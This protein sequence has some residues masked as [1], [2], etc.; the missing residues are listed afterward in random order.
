M[1]DLA[2][3]TRAEVGEQVTAA[4]LESRAEPSAPGP[5]CPSCGQAMRYKGRKHR[6][7]RTRSGAVE[8]ERAYY[9]CPPCGRGQFPLDEGLGLERGSL[10]PALAR[11]VVWL[12]GV[13][14]YEQVS[15]VLERIG[16]YSVPPSTLWEQVQHHGER[17]VV[18]QARQQSQV[19]IERTA[20]ESRR[21]QP[22]LRKGVSLDGG[23]VNIRGEGWKEFKTGVVSTRPTFGR[24]CRPSS[25]TTSNRT[26]CAKICTIWRSWAMSSNLPPPCG[27]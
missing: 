16:Q 24:P 13:V 19:S 22:P 8:M 15:H 21:Y 2:L 14:A 11:A 27:P 12:S 17:R 26:P 10:S 3:R 4:L 9:Y 5:R 7:L 25:K 6:Y 20:W 1:E 23:M 18:Y